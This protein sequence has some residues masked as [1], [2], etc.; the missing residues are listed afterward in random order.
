MLLPNFTGPR[1]FPDKE[2]TPAKMAS[3][4]LYLTELDFEL[5]IC[6][7]GRWR[8][9]GATAACVFLRGSG[10][11]RLRRARS[12]W[13]IHPKRKRTSLVIVRRPLSSACKAASLTRDNKGNQALALRREKLCDCF[14]QN[15]NPTPRNCFFIS[16]LPFSR[17]PD[18]PLHSPSIHHLS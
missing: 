10:S 2:R 12:A 7:G 4:P 17:H 15:P 14:T 3:F 9:A 5:A 18:L 6:E 11:Q 16:L 13:A 8:E 1:T